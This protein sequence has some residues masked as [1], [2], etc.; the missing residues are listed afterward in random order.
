MQQQRD[1]LQSILDTS[2]AGIVLY[3]A[4]RNLSG[5]IIDFR[6]VLTNPANAKT[7]DRTVAEMTGQLLSVVSP[8]AHQ[9]DFFKLLTGVTESGN[10]QQ[11]TFPFEGERIRGWFEASMVRQG[12]GVLFVFQDITALKESEQQQQHQAQLLQ[13][14]MDVAQT[15]ISLHQSIRKPQPDGQPG[16]IQDFRTVLANKQAIN[17]WGGLS[18]RFIRQT[19]WESQADLPDAASIFDR[20]VRV[21]ETGQ[22]TNWEAQLPANDRWHKILAAKAGD[23]VVIA[24]IDITE[25]HLYQQ[26]LV[27]ANESLNQLNEKLNRFAAVASHDLQ[28]PLRKIRL[29][30]D[31]VLDEHSQVLNQEGVTLLTTIQGAAKRMQQ[32][33]NNLLFYAKLEADQTEVESVALGE[34]VQQVIDDLSISME[35]VSLIINPLPKVAGDRIQL[36]QLLQNLL[37]NALKYRRA[38]VSLQIQIT[39]ERVSAAALPQPIPHSIQPSPSEYWCIRF[40]DNGVG[41]DPKHAERIFQSFQRLSH[42]SVGTG[43][44]L[45]IC[46]QVAENHGGFLTATG[47]PNQGAT[48]TLYLPV[49]A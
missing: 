42:Q 38:D 36:S 24:S 37:S 17:D 39:T 7:T 45:A 48:F 29:Y 19:F 25:T 5:Q 4:I 34:L 43:L 11:L 15:S 18:D 12:D 40:I 49:S 47:Q 9:G 23:G 31:I 44:G 16:P 13:T 41:F 26:Q 8:T 20:L 35:S 2:P 10:A 32:L 33:V 3:E 14:V 21:V 30:S 22:P 6:Y 1:L 28:E 27:A 46:K